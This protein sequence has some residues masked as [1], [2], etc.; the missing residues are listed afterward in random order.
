MKG[1]AMATDILHIYSTSGATTLS[2]LSSYASLLMPTMCCF[3][4]RKKSSL[5]VTVVFLVY[6]DKL[7]FRNSDSY[8]EDIKDQWKLVSYGGATTDIT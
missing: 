6:M 5:D 2:P 8:Q 7:V 3:S 4:W 1:L